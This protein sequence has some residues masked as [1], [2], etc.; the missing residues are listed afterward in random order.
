M[1][2]VFRSVFTFLVLLA[3]ASGCT[4]GVVTKKDPSSVKVGM[5]RDEVVKSL[6]KPIATSASNNVEVLRYNVSHSKALPIVAG[7]EEYTF[8]FVDGKLVSYGSSK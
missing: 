3:I 2:Y 6:G 8:R 7:W 5:D 4:F 1:K